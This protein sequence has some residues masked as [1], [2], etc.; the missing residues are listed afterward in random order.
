MRDAA[1]RLNV[2]VDIVDLAESP[3]AA[4]TVDGLMLTGGPDLDP[5][6]Y[7]MGEYAALCTIDAERDELEFRTLDAVAA[8]GAPI[9]AICRGV[10]VLN[11]AHGGSLV[12]D[13][14]DVAAVHHG[15][16]G[17]ADRRHPI[18]VES[19]ARIATLAGVTAGAVATSHHQAVDRV[20]EAFVA[21]ARADDGIIEALE[22]REPQG[23][24]FVIGVQW[25]PERMEADEPF[26]G[27]LFDGWLTAVREFCALRV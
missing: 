9:F 13:L 22:W 24:P 8:R 4:T 7:G 18:V 27:P 11:V 26:A 16:L 12:P 19:G 2:D 25:H 1:A 6:R 21:C 10:Q 14:P 15:P 17:G 5:A 23:K 20:A 3:G